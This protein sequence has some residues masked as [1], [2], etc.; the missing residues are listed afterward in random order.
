MTE[1]LLIPMT[2]TSLEIGE[3]TKVRHD[4]VKQSINRLA[5][6]GVITLPP[7]GEV[8]NPGLGP[9]RIAV[10][11]L[12]KRDSLVVVAQLSPEFTAKVVDRWQA[13]EDRLAAIGKS[14]REKLWELD[15]REVES[16]ARA[17]YGS[18]SLNNRKRE[19]RQLRMERAQLN[20]QIQPSL[21][22]Q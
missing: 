1:T 6:R 16:K 12:S 3:V 2:M 15:A 22:L 18:K 19:L 11:M 8:S 20:A 9:K 14:F 13:L 17:S 7:M 5:A 21:L 10:Y 4:K